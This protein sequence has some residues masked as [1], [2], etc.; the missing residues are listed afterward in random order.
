MKITYVID[1]LAYKGGA[2]R[3]VSEKMS[4][5]A[6]VLGH[7]ISVITCHQFTDTQNTY[8]ISDK[9]R[10]INLGI[11][12]FKQYHY[13]F[14]MRLWV[15]WH[16]HQLLQ[17]LLSERVAELCP[18]ILIG[19][20]YRYADIVCNINSNAAIVI[21]AHEARQYTMSSDFFGKTSLITR[22]FQNLIR[23]KYLKTIEK[24]ADVI[25]TLTQA[26]A[27]EWRKTKRV[28]VIPN[29]SSMTVHKTSDGTK[30]NAIAVGRLSWQKGYERMIEIWQSVTQKHPDWQLNIFG[31]GY[32]QN[33]LNS[34]IQEKGLTNI[35]IHPFTNNISSHYADSSIC[36][37]TS[38]FEGF[39]LILLEAIC[40]GVPGITFD[41]PHGPSDIITDGE[42]G[43][44]IP[45]NDIQQFADKT[46]YLIEHPEV[47]QAFASAALAKARSFDK[48]AIM[49]KWDKLFQT[50][51]PV[52]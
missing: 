29:F 36:L 20:S 40:H 31:E 44:V 46:C 28:E 37:L 39:S 35:S 15:K 21:E 9:V 52:Q 47:R 14:P 43:Y 25:V 51:Y 2:E 38:H 33:Q 10:Q 13:K 19:M 45:D 24:K 26:D 5:L 7:D 12:D 42:C 34:L 22:I 6:D 8:P 17:K 16:Y 50:L 41:C 4:Y 27:N 18:D 30:K 1:S 49:K 11:N 32:L 3:I 48:E 23:Y